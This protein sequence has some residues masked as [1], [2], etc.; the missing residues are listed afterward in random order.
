MIR[1]SARATEKKCEHHNG[2]NHNLLYVV[3]SHKSAEWA[4]VCVCVRA[5]A[6]KCLRRWLS[7][8]RA[9]DVVYWTACTLPYLCMCCTARARFDFMY[10]GM[11]S[12]RFM[13]VCAF[14]VESIVHAHIARRASHSALTVRI[15]NFFSSQFSSFVYLSHALGFTA[16][17][18]RCSFLPSACEALL[19]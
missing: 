5:N 6:Y 7:V 14:D 9:C 19:F 16:P 4:S 3:S 1:R 10:M 15:S 12:S 11:H 8:R 17:A 18:S 2:V 13:C